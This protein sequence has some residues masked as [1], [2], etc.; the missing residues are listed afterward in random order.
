MRPFSRDHFAVWAHAIALAAW[1]LITPSDVAADERSL[2]IAL[3]SRRLYELAERVCRDQ[4]QTTNLSAREQA[5]ALEELMRTLG[6][7]ALELSGAERAEKFD[8]AI[9]EADRFRK[10]HP[11]HPFEAS[12]V[13]QAALTSLARGEVIV[14]EGAMSSRLPAQQQA[15]LAALRQ[16][17]TEIEALAAKL[18]IDIPQRRRVEPKPDEPTADELFILASHLGYHQA[19]ARLL[20]AEMYEP[21]SNDRR[22]LLLSAAE[23]L[24]AVS[25]KLTKEDPVR[26]EVALELIRAW[27]QLG[28]VA[29][30]SELATKLDQE[31]MPRDVRLD[32][33]A[34]A[35]RL[36]FLGKDAVLPDPTA[37]E[38]TLDGS[39]SAEL[40]LAI[41]ELM[42]VRAKQLPA[43]SAEQKEIAGE[44]AEWTSTI[45][46]NHGAYWGRRADNLLLAALPKASSGASELLARSADRLYLQGS[47]EDARQA[48]DEAAASAK[49]AGDLTSAFSLAFKSAM[50]DEQ[51]KRYP[52]AAQ[53]FVAL[54]T[55]DPASAEAST[56]HLRGLWNLAQAAR[57][58]AE[59]LAEYTRELDEH[60]RLWPTAASAQQAAIWRMRLA[61][62]SAELA[63]AIRASALVPRDSDKAE[64]ATQLL[65]ACARAAVIKASADDRMQVA[66]ESVA[67]FELRLL[68]AMR[69]LPAMWSSGDRELVLAA[70][71][72]LITYTAQQALAESML[73][74][75]ARGIPAPDD[76]WTASAARWQMVAMASDPARADDAEEL[77]KRLPVDDLSLTALLDTLE[78]FPAGGKQH[79]QQLASVRLAIVEHW[80]RSATSL[81][82]ASQLTLSRHEASALASLGKWEE[83]LVAFEKL[84]KSHP[85]DARVQEALAELLLDST[86]RTS[87]ER[88]LAQW[89]LVASKS[90]PRTERWFRAKH[91]VATAQLRLGDRAGA[92]ALASFLLASPPGLDGT[93]W[94]L[95]FEQIV[96]E[97][98]R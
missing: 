34:E 12:I 33:R 67:A 30:A 57:S 88:A 50:I 46:S 31:G 40:D 83:A 28:E 54:A 89:R 65:I 78:T 13:L 68:G 86:D 2:V 44:A 60:L 3:R 70:A 43:S 25:T 9:A 71:E 52:A 41:L 55:S 98:S 29:Q 77:V 20:R 15:A 56:A 5:V 66:K 7:H 49:L 75:S 87:L 92:K 27:R 24:V 11:A 19:R 8:E 39:S 18:T 17:E 80:R 95:P 47:L 42:L 79:Q 73:A 48:Y 69:K 62:T 93:A 22:A 6:L 76:A 45:V 84:A 38:R 74:A 35:L 58:S 51:Q 10:T 37:I 91:R 26:N 59:V 97:S 36:L 1:L 32:A 21:T 96:S 4:L 23:T 14:V 81:N 90:R 85:Q 72:L 16:A 64:E 53:K 82:S 63:P 94:K 61:A